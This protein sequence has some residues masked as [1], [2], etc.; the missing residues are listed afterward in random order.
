MASTDENLAEK[1]YCDPTWINYNGGWIHSN[2]GEY[3]S[4]V[5]ES[6]NNVFA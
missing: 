6:E 1:V 3:V 2:N 4:Q 5:R